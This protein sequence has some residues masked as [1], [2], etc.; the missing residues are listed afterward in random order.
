MSQYDF[1]VIDPVT[2]T[3]TELSNWL[4]SWAPALESCHKGAA[5]PSYAIPGMIWVK[6]VSPT[7]WELYLWDGV[8]DVLLFAV[9]PTSGAIVGGA[10]VV[11]PAVSV[12]GYVPLWDGTTGKLLEGGLPVQASTTDATDNVILKLGAFGLGSLN[13]PSVA[14]LNAVTRVGFYRCSG[15][16]TNSPDNISAWAVIH[17][18]WDASPIQ[19]ALMA[20]NA[21][22]Q[23]FVRQSQGGAWASWQRA[24]FAGDY[25]Y[26]AS[27][28]GFYNAAQ[29]DLNS[30][31][32]N[33]IH[34]IDAS[35]SN[36]NTP[37][38][39][40]SN[41]ILTVEGTSGTG[42]FVQQRYAV[43]GGAYHGWIWTR[44]RSAGTW[45]AWQVLGGND[46]PATP[47]TLQN[48]FA[49]GFFP[50]IQYR[51]HSNFCFVQGYATR[52]GPPTDG[53]IVGNVPVGYRPV[54]EARSVGWVHQQGSINAQP[55]DF[56]LYPDGNV[57][58]SGPAGDAYSG[59]PTGNCDVFIPFLMAPLA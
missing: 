4:N 19:I 59:W 36:L 57:A 33:G 30:V 8:H 52:G 23:M 1:P 7:V 17:Q 41:A 21:T 50:A 35:K 43:W 2:N 44:T 13:A 54:Y 56:V 40:S 22:T 55:W 45:S 37:D 18:C 15:A 25:G 20:G 27:N 51:R 12:D 48:G 26:G 11:G 9:N 16:G 53:L 24:L 5:R 46:T 32:V 28:Q 3:G 38:G 49:G 39:N 29:I 58:C 10:Y 31:T 34:H 14:D 42:T 6:E 47:L